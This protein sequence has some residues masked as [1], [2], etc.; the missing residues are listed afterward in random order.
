[1]HTSVRNGLRTGQLTVHFA[2]SCLINEVRCLD[3]TLFIIYLDTCMYP[4]TNAWFLTRLHAC[5]GGGGP[6]GTLQS[7]CMRSRVYPVI[8]VTSKVMSERM[9]YLI[10]SQ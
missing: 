1:M 6:E 5:M 8:H 2:W 10:I 3:A 7:A 4:L 9:M